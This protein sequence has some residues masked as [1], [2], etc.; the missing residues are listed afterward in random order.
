[1]VILSIIFNWQL[2]RNSY[3]KIG[4][5]NDIDVSLKQTSYRDDGIH[6]FN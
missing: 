6:L 5:Y 1:M 2:L 4:D 3:C